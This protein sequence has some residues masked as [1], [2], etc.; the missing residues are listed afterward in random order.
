M[1]TSGGFQSVHIKGPAEFNGIKVI[2]GDGTELHRKKECAI[3][4]I[5]FKNNFLFKHTYFSLQTI[6]H[7]SEL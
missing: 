2:D 4:E 7:C 1:I 3:E 5:Y 6:R